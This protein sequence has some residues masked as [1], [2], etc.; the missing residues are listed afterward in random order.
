MSGVETAVNSANNYVVRSTSD[1]R[2]KTDIQ[3]ETLGLN[4][5]DKIQPKVYR[6][7]SNPA[8][9]QHGWIAQDIEQL[10]ML[11]EDD[12][13]MYT[14]DDGFKSSDYNAME[15]PIILAIQQLHKKIKELQELIKND[16][17]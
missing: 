9:R 6:L 11:P 12:A 4:F 7:K 3:P 13:L 2:K 15:G 8:V 14:Y 10:G 1:E 16:E 5:I 17:R